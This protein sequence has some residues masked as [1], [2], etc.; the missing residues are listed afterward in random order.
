MEVKDYVEEI[1]QTACSFFPSYRPRTFYA[2]VIATIVATGWFSSDISELIGP[3]VHKVSGGLAFLANRVVDI[4]TSL[5]ITKEMD[6]PRFVEY[7]LNKYYREKSPLVVKHPTPREFITP[8]MLIGNLIG[9]AI[10]STFGPNLGYGMAAGTP[11]TYLNNR[12]VARQI[13]L[14]KNIGDEVKAMIENDTPDADI[15]Q[16]LS[17]LKENKKKTLDT[18]LI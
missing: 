6:D 18:Y 13:R 5:K 1:T 7:D 14:G 9:L 11:Q 16:F 3:T 4:G 12:N 17:N 10:S 15:R 2:T 8:T